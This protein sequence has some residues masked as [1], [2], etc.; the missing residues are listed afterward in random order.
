MTTSR[1]PG[2]WVHPVEILMID[3]AMMGA[4]KRQWTNLKVTSRM[5]TTKK[6]RNKSRTQRC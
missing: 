3:K 2:R 5:E 1:Y 4:K 6:P